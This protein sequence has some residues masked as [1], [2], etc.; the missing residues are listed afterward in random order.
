MNSGDLNGTIERITLETRTIH[1]DERNVSSPSSIRQ[2]VDRCWMYL[3]GAAYESRVEAR[4]EGD[5]LVFEDLGIP[6]T[7]EDRGTSFSDFAHIVL[8]CEVN[9]DEAALGPDELFRVWFSMD[10]ETGASLVEGPPSTVQ[11]TLTLDQN[12]DP[13]VEG[14][15]LYTDIVRR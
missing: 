1:I 13:R 12:T 9:P 8:L 10:W 2:V 6:V 11:G 3:F 15:S 4:F 14:T 5:T 7:T